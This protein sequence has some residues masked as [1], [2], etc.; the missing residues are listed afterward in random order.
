[1]AE[2][3]RKFDAIVDFAEV[4]RFL[5]TPVKRYSSGMYVR[6]AFAVAAH[7]NPEILIVDEVLAVG[8]AQFQ[9]KCLGKMEDVSRQE[10]RTVLFVSHNM[11]AVRA[12]CRS[13]LLMRGGRIVAFS[14]PGD[15]CSQYLE[16]LQNAPERLDTAM[17]DRMGTGALRLVEAK[18]LSGG[19]ETSTLVAGRDVAFEY[20]YRCREEVGEVMFTM[21]VF[22]SYGVGVASVS[23]WHTGTPLAL[24]S[25]TG[26]IR[27]E[28]PSF[29][30]NVGRYRV[31]VSVTDR[32]GQTLDHLSNILAFNVDSVD[33]FTTG[34]HPDP[35]YSLVVVPHV[36]SVQPR[37]LAAS[38]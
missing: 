28:I 31:A 26:S 21:T 13:A 4:E 16:G 22:N 35:S 12:L 37:V 9:Q 8:D 5:D 3:K 34:I 17:T 30:C 2:T 27:C 6:L 33:F 24:R 15:I 29:P 1:E 23:N 10:G 11:A 25:A 20:G 38:T 32:N 19:I 7:L 36:W 18:I 14:N